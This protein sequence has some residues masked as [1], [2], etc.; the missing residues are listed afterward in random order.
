MHLIGLW[1]HKLKV[2]SQ[3]QLHGKAS[4]TLNHRATIQ[5]QYE[6][7][8]CNKPLEDVHYSGF[9]VKLSRFQ[10]KMNSWII[11]YSLLCHSKPVWLSSVEHRYLSKK[12][13]GHTGFEQHMVWK[14][15]SLNENYSLFYTKTLHMISQNFFSTSDMQIHLCEA[16]IWNSVNASSWL[17]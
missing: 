1:Q 11:I 3:I 6:L 16:H 5:T 10:L 7:Y 2:N 12:K 14:K 15:N 4:A 9:T 13:E 8:W 17:K